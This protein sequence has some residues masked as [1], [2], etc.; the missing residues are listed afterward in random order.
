ME[1]VKC[2][3]CVKLLEIIKGLWLSYMRWFYCVQAAQH[4]KE[5]KL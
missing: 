4:R 1:Q 5:K 2:A 3:A